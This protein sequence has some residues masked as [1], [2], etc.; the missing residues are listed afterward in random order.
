MAMIE[1]KPV[2]IIGV[3]PDEPSSSSRPP[4]LKGP[5]RPLPLS[6]PVLFTAAWFTLGGVK[7]V[8]RLIGRSSLEELMQLPRLLERTAA[9]LIAF[10]VPEAY[11]L[12]GIMEEL[13]QLKREILN[14]EGLIF[15]TRNPSIG[16]LLEF[17]S[18]QPSIF[19]Y[20][21]G[22]LEKLKSNLAYREG[23]HP[24]L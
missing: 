12:K 10:G 11:K 3:N 6:G 1:D 5:F 9:N 23:F 18:D 4:Q 20:A 2:D 21:E 22:L 7:D 19:C 14:L 24:T 15:P 13:S 16:P 17:Y 8:H